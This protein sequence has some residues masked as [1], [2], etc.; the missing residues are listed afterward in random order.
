MV[1]ESFFMLLV[2][3]VLVGLVA[4]P[5]A[6]L[7]LLIVLLRR[8]QEL[9]QEV[10]QA[11][12]DLLVLKQWWRNAVPVA[13]PQ[14]APPAPPPAPPAGQPVAVPPP[15]IPSPCLAASR[16]PSSAPVAAAAVAKATA[17]LPPLGT[18]SVPRAID[19]PPSDQ[20]VPPAS[21]ESAS[22][23]LLRRGWNW[24]LFGSDSLPPGVSLEYAIASNWL[25]RLGI[26]IGV[27]GL[28][29]F[30]I[31]SVER[32][33]IGP[34]GRSAI[35]VLAGLAMIVGG[36][37][38]VGRKYHLLGLGLLGGGLVALYWSVYAITM[39]HAILSAVWALPMMVVVTVAAGILAVRLHS[40]L[41]A[42]IGIVGGYGSPILMQMPE[43]DVMGILLYLSI[44]GAGI[45]G[46]SFWRNWHLLNYLGMIF[47]YGIVFS[48]HGQLAAER[49]WLV[50]PFL[51]LFFAFYAT[52][53]HAHNFVR[54]GKSTLVEMAGQALNS[55]FFFRLGQLLT[56]RAYSARWTAVLTL[57]LAAFFTLHLLLFIHR[58]LRDRPLLVMLTGLAAFYLTI[59]MPILLS[60]QWLTVSWAAQALLMLWA[61]GK[62]NSNFLRQLAYALYGIT[63]VRL[64]VFDFGREFG[65]DSWT[66]MTAGGY[67][68][69][70]GD[71]LVV[72]AAPILS[73]F[74]GFWLQA[75]TPSPGPLA[76]ERDNDLPGE[77]TRDLRPGFFWAA[78]L[79]AFFYMQVEAH[80]MFGTLCLPV[81]P[82]VGTALWVALCALL[83]HR[84][85]A[86]DG[87]VAW[88]LLLIFLPA[89]VVKL[90]F[91]DLP[92]WDFDPAAIAC[93]ADAYQIVD[94]GV[95]AGDFAVVLL[96]LAWGGLA[97]GRRGVKP[98]HRRAWFGFLGLALLFFYL[99][100]EVNTALS[101]FW[102]GFRAGA[103][104]ILWSLFA[105][106]FVFYGLRR[107]HGRLRYLGLALFLVVVVKVLLSDL[108]TLDA[109]FRIVA[110]LLLGLI[111]TGGAFVYLF[112][113]Q[114]P[115]ATPPSDRV[116]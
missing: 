59:T 39:F 34:V 67:W 9:R 20:E 97:G 92:L 90:L 66:D 78:I 84:T 30:L 69:L 2:G 74:G 63:L 46:I 68:R 52:A 96:L 51:A 61:A 5:V 93:R 95:R 113:R 41:V 24:F 54:R 33:M 32:G 3:L 76:V 98:G 15:A 83:L 18:P 110:F 28:G 25:L 73:L 11:Q 42:V 17:S 88:P 8:H 43:A 27:L 23:A 102:T 53:M 10:Q 21:L 19:L 89:T 12:S 87:K 55:L 116:S 26:L 36:L 31:Y 91:F 4:V 112:F 56:A 72:F 99:T 44:L 22:K 13:A 85:L 108:A 81:R 103:V 7:V 64:L 101:F 57:A 40:P 62:L 86:G 82:A 111:V 48:L 71:R 35:S 49:F 77:A 65:P 104:S 50:M 94:A 16:L 79:L 29:F 80:S 60:S 106:A 6:S 14:P 100:L 38:L 105:F 45:L 1:M 70:L 75:H 107:N 58:R 115:A 37:R 47:T 114:P 109:L